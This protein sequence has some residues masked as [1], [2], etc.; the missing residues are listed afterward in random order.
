MIKLTVPRNLGRL[1]LVALRQAWA[2][3]ARDFTP[4][5]AE[6]ENL[7]LLGEA[8][9]LELEHEATEKA[10]GLFSADILARDAL[11]NGRVLIE[12]QLEGTDHRHL[13]QILTYAAG[14]DARTVVWIAQSFREEHRAAID[15]LNQAT[16]SDFNFFGV[17]IELYRIG[18]S[19]LAPSFNVIAKPNDWTRQVSAAARVAEGVESANQKRW[20]QFWTGL[21]AE[22]RGRNLPLGAYAPANSTWQIAEWLRGGDPRIGINANAKRGMLRLVA[23]ID[24]EYAKQTFAQLELHVTAMQELA[25]ATLEFNP[26]PKNRAARIDI[27]HPIGEVDDPAVWPQYYEWFLSNVAAFTSAI[28]RGIAEV[29]FDALGDGQQ[30]EDAQ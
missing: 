26:L 11:S 13:G 8:V 16:T 29:D 23:Y 18:D 4:W 5:L 30:E 15:W 3:E 7:A 6:A 12:N 17:E 27:S 1:E 21:I 22:A 28:K 19:P 24:G 10:V 25:P 20:R 14:L 2:D 9:G